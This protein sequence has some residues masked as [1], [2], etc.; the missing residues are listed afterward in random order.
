MFTGIVEGQGVVEALQPRGQAHRLTID[1]GGL[2]ADVTVGDSVAIDGTCLTAV[3]VQGGRVDFDVIRETIERTAF[4][5]VR[6]K[7][8]VNVERSMRADGR[9]HGHIVSGHVDGTGRIAE[10]RQEPGQVL[11]TVEVPTRLTTLMVEKGSICIDGV[12]LTLVDVRP[13][14]FSVALIPH[15][16]EVTTLGLKPPGGLVNIEVDQLGKWVRRLLAA[17]V[18]AAAADEAADRPATPMAD[19]SSIIVAPR[20]ALSLTVDDLRRTGLLGDA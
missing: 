10:R 19:G 11:F 18:P 20:A 15:T 14:R 17:Y 2:A 6:V 8:R 12:S 1:M 5:T 4:A 3:S 9:F 7:D 16:L 13:G